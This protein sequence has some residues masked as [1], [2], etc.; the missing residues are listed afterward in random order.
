MMIHGHAIDE[1]C[2][3]E[4]LEFIRKEI[5]SPIPPM[6]YPSIERLLVIA[7]LGLASVLFLAWLFLL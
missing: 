6:N 3:A 5:P 2:T 1:P 7:C 4:C